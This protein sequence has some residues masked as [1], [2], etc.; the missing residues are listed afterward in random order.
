MADDVEKYI[1]ELGSEDPQVR[2]NA[3]ESL[4]WIV[5]QLIRELEDAKKAV[6]SAEAEYGYIWSSSYPMSTLGA[7]AKEVRECKK[8][9]EIISDN[10]NYA[11][12]NICKRIA[13][14]YPHIICKICFHRFKFYPFNTSSFLSE[15]SYCVCRNCR[16]IEFIHPVKKI[17]AVFDK[18]MQNYTHENSNLY[19]NWLSIKKPFDFN[20]VQVLNASDFDISEFIM[21]I[22]NDMDREFVRQYKNI[23]VVVK[24]ELSQNSKNLLKNTFKEVKFE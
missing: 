15:H 6:E 1:K 8:R 16:S 23:R 11:K 22:R 9:Y 12:D 2:M 4:G 3:A 13:S 14:F 18:T 19:V 20:E 17:I 7:C 21:K 5:E 24:C 10:V